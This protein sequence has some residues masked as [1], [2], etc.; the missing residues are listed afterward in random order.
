M[1]LL[2]IFH[3][4]EQKQKKEESVFKIKEI[5][6]VKAWKNNCSKISRRSFTMA[7]TEHRGGC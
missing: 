5:A 7:G 2:N 3:C 1:C 6:C 4:L